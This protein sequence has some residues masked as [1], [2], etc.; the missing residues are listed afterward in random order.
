MGAGGISARRRARPSWRKLNI[1]GVAFLLALVALWQ[2]GKDTG[3]IQSEF[4]PSPTEIVSATGDLL[5]SG[6]LTANVWHTLYVTVAGWAIAALLGIGLGLLLGLSPLIWRYSM[7]SVEFLRA[8]PAISFVPIGVLLLGFSVKTELLVVVYVSVW[9]I[10]VNTVHGARSVTPLHNDLAR[11]LR[12][13]GPSF[14]RR[15]VLPTTMPFV[16]VGL[17]FALALS[18]ALA[19]VAE[20][21]G[22][23]EGIGHGLITAQNTLQPAQMFSYVVIVGLL[24]LALNAAFLKVAG[25]LFPTAAAAMKTGGA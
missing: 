7:T 5:E 6:E 23:P 17:Q 13:D 22:N 2:I 18:L 1:E 24:G 21:I 9:P 10:L 11:M 8:L 20:M 19:L 3:A 25:R 16:L 14:V 15:I 12:L 4:L